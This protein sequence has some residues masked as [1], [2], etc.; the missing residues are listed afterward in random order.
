LTGASATKRGLVLRAG[1]PENVRIYIPTKYG[2][3]HGHLR[4]GVEGSVRMYTQ[5][6]SSSEEPSSSAK[7]DT[8]RI[9]DEIPHTGKLQCTQTTLYMGHMRKLFGRSAP[10]MVNICT[11]CNIMG[12]LS[13]VEVQG[14][15]TGLAFCQICGK[16]EDS[17]KSIAVDAPYKV[18]AANSPGL[19]L[20][21]SIPKQ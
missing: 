19:D 18:F 11:A 20:H 14:M 2:P 3:H 8:I 7:L 5:L 9:T 4:H 17:I 15:S 13:A 6:S 1:V 21:I 10:R 16:G 12:S